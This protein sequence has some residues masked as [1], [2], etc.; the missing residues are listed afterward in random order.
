[1]PLITKVTVFN[2]QAGQP[3][4]MAIRGLVNSVGRVIYVTVPRETTPAQ[5][6]EALSSS[7]AEWD[8][9]A[10]KQLELNLGIGTSS[11]IK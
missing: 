9:Y 7:A 5:I 3:I 4:A 8:K 6:I 10:P 1:M 2:G 11:R